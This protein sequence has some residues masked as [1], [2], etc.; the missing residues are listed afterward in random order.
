MS[1]AFIIIRSGCVGSENGPKW[2][3]FSQFTHGSRMGFFELK[4]S[5]VL[6]DLCQPQVV[7]SCWLNWKRPGSPMTAP[8]VLLFY[9]QEPAEKSGRRRSWVGGWMSG[10]ADGWVGGRRGRRVNRLLIVGSGNTGSH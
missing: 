7:L 6:L 5:V 2:L 3:P 9:Q 10:W 8:H 4:G 1:F